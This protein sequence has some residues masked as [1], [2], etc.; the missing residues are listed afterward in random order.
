[1]VQPHGAA[2]NAFA[3]PTY[4]LWGYPTNQLIPNYTKMECEKSLTGFLPT[5]CRATAYVITNNKCT[6]LDFPPFVGFLLKLLNIRNIQIDKEKSAGFPPTLRGATAYKI[7]RKRPK[8]TEE[9]A[10][11][12]GPKRQNC[13]MR[14]EQEE[15]PGLGQVSSMST[16]EG[17]PKTRKKHP[18]NRAIEAKPDRWPRKG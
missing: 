6:L 14:T 4:T 18:P 16:R 13:P 10:G 7:E 12:P 3:I 9:K 5:L 17:H 15:R 11:R 8:R 2:I 1:M